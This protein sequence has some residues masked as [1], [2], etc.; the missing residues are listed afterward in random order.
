MIVQSTPLIIV[1][2]AAAKARSA[3]PVL[4]R[5]L[6]GAGLEFDLHETTQPGDATTRT[7]AALEAG[8]TLIAVVGGDGTLSEA[9]QGF[10]QFGKRIEDLPA[11]IN[12][13]ACL[14]ILPAGTGDDF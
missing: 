11:P 9:A 2:H 3:W 7:R 1:N 10:F 5:R 13:D 12:P 6:E 14:A 8:T 4:R